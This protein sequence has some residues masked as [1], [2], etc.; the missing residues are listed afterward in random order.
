MWTLPTMHKW[1]RNWWSHFQK[2]RGKNASV[3]INPIALGSNKNDGPDNVQRV[4]KSPESPTTIGKLESFTDYDL[5]NTK[6]VTPSMHLINAPLLYRKDNS[7][8][9][10]SLVSDICIHHSGGHSCYAYTNDRF[11]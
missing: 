4:E 5:G 10:S 9:H 6:N 2:K 11:F 8:G 1:I 3:F 7:V